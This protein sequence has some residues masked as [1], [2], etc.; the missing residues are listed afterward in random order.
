MN[1]QDAIKQHVALTDIPM[2]AE[3]DRELI[4]LVAKSEP[5]MTAEQPQPFGVYRS[6]ELRSSG[7]EFP[8]G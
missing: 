3:Y 4:G 2:L 1:E 8:K 5:G 7:V 6:S